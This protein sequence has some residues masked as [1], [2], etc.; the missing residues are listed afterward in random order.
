MNLRI[1]LV[2]VLALSG[3]Q[4]TSQKGSVMRISGKKSNV[5]FSVEVART[6]EE[7]Q[8]GLMFRDSLL[9][10]KGMIF[11]FDSEGNYPFWMKDTKIPLD[12]VYFDSDW[13]VVGILEGMEPMSRA[14]RGIEK[15]SRY[16]LEINAGLVQKEGVSVGDV[17]S[18]IEE[19]KHD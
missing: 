17:G 5:E 11:I 14:S 10:N 16:V 15:Q 13:K 6:N 7:R 12:L 3:C 19:K 18:F 1:F 2:L 9:Q 8:R 4:C